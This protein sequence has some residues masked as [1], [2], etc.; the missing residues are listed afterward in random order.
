MPKSNLMIT[1]QE[2][3]SEKKDEPLRVDA[4]AFKYPCLVI[5]PEGDI[6]LAISP[7]LNVDSR[8]NGIILHGNK[9]GLVSDV[10]LKQRWHEYRGPRTFTLGWLMD[11]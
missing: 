10:L 6:A 1:T 11:K 4:L 7:R 8:F 2:N 5:N 3:L 9:V